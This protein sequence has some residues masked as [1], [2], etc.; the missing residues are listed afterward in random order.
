MFKINGYKAEE[1]KKFINEY[2]MHKGPLTKLFQKWSEKTGKSKGTI[3]NMY[4]ALAK[5]SRQDKEFCEEYLDGVPIR[6]KRA[7]PFSR[8]EKENLMKAVFQRRAQGDSVRSAVL[9]LSGGDA[10]IALRLQNKYRNEIK[11]DKNYGFNPDNIFRDDKLQEIKDGIDC[12]IKRMMDRVV[13]ENEILKERIG[14]LELKNLQL[15]GKNKVKISALKFL[16][17][18]DGESRG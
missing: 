12:L 9:S 6:T 13:K 4:Y 18:E 8:T 3:R 10:K 5:K 1:V 17:G 15:Q 16:S 11:S 7:E 2:R 14:Y